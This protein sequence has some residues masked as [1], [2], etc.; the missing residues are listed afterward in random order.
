[1]PDPSKPLWLN[2]E[3]KLGIYVATPVHSNVSIHYTQSLL[4]FQKACMKKGVKVMF[5]MIKSSLVTQGST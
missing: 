5:E 1:M 4:E 2:Q 3:R